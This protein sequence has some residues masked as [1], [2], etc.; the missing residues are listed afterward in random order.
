MGVLLLAIGATLVLSALRHAITPEIWCLALSSA[1]SIGLLEIIRA[2]R[3]DI[4]AVYLIDGI[5]QVGILALWGVNWRWV[6]TQDPCA[7]QH[8]SRRPLPIQGPPAAPLAIPVP[9]AATGSSSESAVSRS[10]TGPPH[11]A[12]F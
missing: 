1:V 5:L 4:S 11:S 8:S 3:K 9:P 7:A 2:A 6:R 12:A 10:P